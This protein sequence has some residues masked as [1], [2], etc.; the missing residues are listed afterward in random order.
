MEHNNKVDKFPN[1][2]KK[3]NNENNNEKDETIRK[4]I[5]RRNKRP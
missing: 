5:N 2:K 4:K 1:K 3:Q